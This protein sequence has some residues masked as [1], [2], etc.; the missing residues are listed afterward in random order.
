MGMFTGWNHSDLGRLDGNGDGWFISGGGIR[1]QGWWWATA[2]QKETG[3]HARLLIWEK[4]NE[5]Q[6]DKTPPQISNADLPLLVFV[7]CLGSCD[8]ASRVKKH[9][10]AIFVVWGAGSC[11]LFGCIYNQLTYSP[12]ILFS[13]NPP[14]S[15]PHSRSV[16]GAMFHQIWIVHGCER[17]GKTKLLESSVRVVTR[18]SLTTKCVV[19][20]SSL[21]N[22]WVIAR[23]LLMTKLVITQ[24]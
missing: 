5:I 16:G 12:S 20:W 10:E 21:M 3:S 2:A 19:T 13:I 15:H 22:K 23:L 8:N 24:S 14:P 9:W 4:M 18:S 17:S 7:H 1:F 11:C 6:C